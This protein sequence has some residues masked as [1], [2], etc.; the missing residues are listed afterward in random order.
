MKALAL[1]LVGSGLTPLPP[2]EDRSVFD[3]AGV[4]LPEDEARL[5][6]QNKELLQKTGVSL[7]ILTVPKLVDETISDLAVRF[8]SDRGVGRK[9]EDKGVVVAFA[10]GDRKIFVATG[11]GVEG[12]LPDGRVGAILDRA[13]MPYLRKGQFSAG[14]TAL[15]AALA[16]TVADHFKVKL[17]GGIPVQTPKGGEP[18]GPLGIV[19]FV[20]TL[21]LFGY[22]AIRHP[23][24]LLLLLAR[25]R[26]GRGGYGGGGFGSGDGFG[27]FGGGG[28]GGGGAGRTF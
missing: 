11:Y 4:L 20:L 15:A 6:A 21:L 19:G 24:L 3:V 26:G 2:A 1:V 27:G 9:G 23:W 28:F 16:A 10:E 7:V 18:P 8:G 14:L 13:A 25:G 12:F 22:L 17:V 5:E